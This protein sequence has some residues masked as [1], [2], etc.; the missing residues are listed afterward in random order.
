MSNGWLIGET[1]FTFN[2]CLIFM[3]FVL[4]LKEKLV[5]VTCIFFYN[6]K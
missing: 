1:N 2:E 3:Y 4:Y 5:D 6:L